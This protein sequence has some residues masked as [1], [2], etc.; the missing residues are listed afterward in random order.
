MD[1]DTDK[2]TSTAAT[3]NTA[4][5]TPL[6]HNDDT[7][8]NMNN[9]TFLDSSNT[10]T[11]TTTTALPPRKRAKTQ[12]E[13]EQRKIERILR[14]RRAAHASREKKRRHVEYLEVYVVKLE[15][16]LQK[17][18][19]GYQQLLKKLSVKDQVSTEELGLEDVSEL[20]S[21]IHSNLNGSRRGGN[22]GS[23]KGRG[24]VEEDEDEECEEGEGEG[25]EHSDELNE[26]SHEVESTPDVHVKVESNLQSPPPSKKRKY[27]S[28]KKD[29]TNTTTTPPPSTRSSS[30]TSPPAHRVKVDE[31][32]ANNNS[33]QPQAVNDKTFYNYLS[34][35]S[36]HSSASSPMDFT[37]NSKA[38][39]N[40]FIFGEV[41]PATREQ[42]SIENTTTS[43]ST[44]TL[45]EFPSQ[46]PSIEVNTQE[47]N[48][49]LYESGQNSAVI[50]SNEEEKQQPPHT[51]VEILEKENRTMRS[52]IS[53]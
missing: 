8:T 52:A 25:E 49:S 37:L 42:E 17:L 21:Q 16:N 3:T 36:I 45:K 19:S 51:L 32:E 29:K 24:Q 22:S 6:S 11:T 28:P 41:K 47:S 2:D 10:T 53:V 50:L 38:D 13:K 5:T 27:S 34:P 35:I 44:N 39:F 14:N 9:D 1:M 33:L 23:R 7:A 26:S 46:T 48:L 15:E 18:S 4:T 30:I 43:H 20:K 12:E 31:A 40:D